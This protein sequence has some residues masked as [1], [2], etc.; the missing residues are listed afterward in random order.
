VRVELICRLREGSEARGD[1]EEALRI[2]PALREARLNLER[3]ASTGDSP[4]SP[5]QE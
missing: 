5:R 3:L 1:F 2:K 4:G